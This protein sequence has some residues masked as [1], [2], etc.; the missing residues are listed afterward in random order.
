MAR[1]TE[2]SAPPYGLAV[3]PVQLLP[4]RVPHLAHQGVGRGLDPP[5][6]GGARDP[7]DDGEHDQRHQDGRLAQGEV[8]AALA[9][10][11]GDQ[12]V[13]SVRAA[14][15]AQARASSLPA[16]EASSAP[17]AASHARFD[18]GRN[19]SGRGLRL[20]EIGVIGN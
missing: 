5:R 11:N 15:R 12:F 9:D 17:V 3:D 7:H 13:F 19:T 10:Y 4:A 1:E 2:R 14:A 6:E 8:R 20:V 18:F 16:C